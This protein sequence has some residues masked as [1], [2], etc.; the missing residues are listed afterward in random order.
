MEIPDYLERPS[1]VTRDGE[2]GMVLAEH[3]RWAGSLKQDISRV[4]MEELS[5]ALPPGASVVSWK[6]N[7]PLDCRVS[8]EV[9]RLDVNPGRSVMLRAQWAVFGRDQKTPA[10]LSARSF[11]EPVAGGDFAAA[12]AGIGKAVGRLGEAITADIRSIAAREGKR[13][14]PSNP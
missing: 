5:A 13:T 9:T 4:L 1:I 6:R 10:T 14:A 8:V 3:D 2:N 7:F 12:V 11:T